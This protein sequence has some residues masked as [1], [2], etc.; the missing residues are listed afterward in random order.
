MYY[1]SKLNGSVGSA[2][3]VFQSLRCVA[4]GHLNASACHFSIISKNPEG[5]HIIFQWYKK[6]LK[7]F[8]YIF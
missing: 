4:T 3:V 6:K 5:H 2:V 7:Q 1:L 8:N